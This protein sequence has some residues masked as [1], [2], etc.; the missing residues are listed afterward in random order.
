MKIAICAPNQS[1]SSET[2]IANHVNRLNGEIYFLY[3]GWLPTMY[4]GNPILHAHRK[5]ISARIIRII[6]RLRK[7]K[8]G[9]SDVAVAFEGFLKRHKIDVVLA[10]YGTTGA[11]IGPICKK[12]GIPFV[13]HFH[14]FDA[15]HHETLKS[16]SQNYKKMFKSAAAVVAV[17][18]HMKN[19][20]VS[21]GCPENKIELI[22]YGVDT[23]LFRAL[24]KKQFHKTFISVG[25]F[26]PKKAP[27]L[28]ILAFSKIIRDFPDARLIMAGD[29]GLG[30]NHE[31][32]IACKQM[33]SAIGVESNVTF[34][35]AIPHDEVSRLMKESD[36]FLQH[37][38]R[39]ETGDSEGTPNSVIEASGSGLCVVATK[40]AGIPDVIVHNETGFLCKELDVPQMAEYMKECLRNPEKTIQ[41]G[42]S[43]AE[44][45][46]KNFDLSIQLD[47]LL[48]VLKSAV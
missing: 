39:S 27:Q 11:A 9:V 19:Q 26:V 28:T 22:Y 2:F 30:N 48:Y 31:L 47:K 38:V 1:S 41:M 21:L 20:L 40:H 8:E 43:G 37:S 33:A 45:I 17:S 6:K 10:E 3:N 14:G 15:Y 44:R 13:V 5:T 12:N 29:G 23:E 32:W 36:V 46:I 18:E 24:K 4:N 42:K 34:T 25:R 35:G 16:N 7:K